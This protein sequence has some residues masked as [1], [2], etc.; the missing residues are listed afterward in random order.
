[1]PIGYSRRV[2]LQYNLCSSRHGIRA[3]YIATYAVFFYESKHAMIHF[4]TSIFMDMLKKIICLVLI[5]S[6]QIFSQGLNDLSFGTDSTF[7]VVT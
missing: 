7:D 5:S 4:M 6:T 1:M 2:H 3:K